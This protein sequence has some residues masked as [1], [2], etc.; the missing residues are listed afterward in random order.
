VAASEAAELWARIIEG[1]ALLARLLAHAATMSLTA[2]CG[3]F[4]VR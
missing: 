3:S 2:W 1:S 4:V